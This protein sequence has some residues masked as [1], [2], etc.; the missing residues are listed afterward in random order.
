MRRFIAVFIFFVSVCMCCQQA[1]ALEAAV[2][3][4]DLSHAYEGTF[5]WHGETSTQRVLITINQLS[6]D[7]NGNVVAAATGE[8]KAAEGVAKID[9]KLQI[10]PDSL[11][12]EMWE[13]GPKRGAEFVS[14][15]S[16]IGTISE[17][18]KTIN[19]VWTT[20][21]TGKQGTLSLKA[22]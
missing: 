5:N 11:R 1:Q 20:K 7:L 6:V 12:F 3:R 13:M 18:L 4:H 10:S 19:T 9:V 15:G 14:E 8:Y 2:V 21:S 22:K 16:H 17:I